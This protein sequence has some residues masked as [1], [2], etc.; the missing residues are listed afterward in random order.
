MSAPSDHG[1]TPS[2]SASASPVASTV[3]GQPAIQAGRPLRVVYAGTPVF[4]AQALDALIGSRHEVVAVLS[5]V[6]K[7]AAATTATLLIERFKVDRIVFTGTAG[8]ELV[9]ATADEVGERRTRRGVPAPGEHLGGQRA[10][11][12][13]HGPCSPPPRPPGWRPR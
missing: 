1:P 12:V 3:S 10:A 8:G 13:R 2:S 7:V 5:R 11:R 6:G 4:A 9:R